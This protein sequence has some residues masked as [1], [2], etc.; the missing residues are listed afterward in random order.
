M[1]LL[2][3]MHFDRT[4]FPVVLSLEVSP[5]GGHPNDFTAQHDSLTHASAAEV[6]FIFRLLYLFI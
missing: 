2:D 1:G 3:L 6:F 5:T 4:P